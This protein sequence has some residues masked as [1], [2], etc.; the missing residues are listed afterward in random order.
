MS[1]VMQERLPFE[2]LRWPEIAVGRRIWRLPAELIKLGPN[3]FSFSSK[4]S[5]HTQ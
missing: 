4:T 1:G 2:T 5:D 3:E